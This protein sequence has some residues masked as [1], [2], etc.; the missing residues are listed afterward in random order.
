MAEYF[1]VAVDDVKMPTTK[2][3]AIKA[4][5]EAIEASRQLLAWAFSDEIREMKEKYTSGCAEAKTIEVRPFRTLGCCD[6]CNKTEVIRCRDCERE[7]TCR[8]AQRLG[9]DGYCSESERKN[10]K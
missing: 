5:R 6:E 2:E 8:L 7:Q 3:E 1:E 10:D 4:K 9:E